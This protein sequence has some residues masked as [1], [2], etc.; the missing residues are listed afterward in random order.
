MTQDFVQEEFGCLP[1]HFNILEG[2]A[3]TTEEWDHILPGFLLYPE[4]FRGALPYLLASIVYHEEFI[5]GNLDPRHPIFSSRLFT[6]PPSRFA[7]LRAKVHVGNFKNK[8]TGMQ[9]CGTEYGH[10]I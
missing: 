7:E 1:P 4:S 8:A 5:R 10:S 6:L 9:A 3:L 2:P